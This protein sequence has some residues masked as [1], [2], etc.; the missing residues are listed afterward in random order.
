MNPVIAPAAVELHGVTL[1]FSG[2]LQRD[3]VAALWMTLPTGKWSMLDLSHV[4][5]LDTAGLA[6]LV[7]VAARGRRAGG[8]TQQILNAPAGYD[9]LC[10][11]YRIR[12][13]LEDCPDAPQ[14]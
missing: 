10:A 14:V 1:W 3:A 5:A 12:P 6:L 8:G 9:A 13:D 7:E 4:S 11:A 2:R